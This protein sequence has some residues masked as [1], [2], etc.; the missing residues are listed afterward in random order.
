MFFLK[1]NDCLYV[2]AFLWCS[3]YVLLV[4]VVDSDP[5]IRKAWTNNNAES[6]NHVVK[7]YTG[8]CIHSGVQWS[9]WPVVHHFA[10]YG[11]RRREGHGRRL[12]VGEAKQRLADH[13]RRPSGRPVR[14][15]PAGLRQTP[16]GSGSHSDRRRP[17]SAQHDQGCSQAGPT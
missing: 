7:T 13:E 2:L 10:G 12:T 3:A 4:K 6:Y 8:L 11:G 15:V 9:A 1:V 5:W 14:Q 17:Q 16:A